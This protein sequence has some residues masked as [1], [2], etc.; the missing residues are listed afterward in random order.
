MDEW[1][2]VYR[3][4]LAPPDQLV[5]LVAGASSDEQR[6][7]GAYLGDRRLQQL[8]QLATQAA[9]LV[10]ETGREPVVFV[11]GFLGSALAVTREGESKTVWL[12]QK[13]IR[14]G[15]LRWLRLA[16]DGR[17][18]FDPGIEVRATSVLNTL[19][20]EL[21]L[22]LTTRWNV[23]AFAYDWRKDMG[24]AAVELEAFLRAE[25][26]HEP[27][28]VVAHSSGATV[29]RALLAQRGEAG[30][31]GPEIVRLIALGEPIEGTFVVPRILA[32]VDPMVVRLGRWTAVGQPGQADVAAGREVAK[33]FA[34]FPALYQM[35]PR[36]AR[37]GAGPGQLGR[38]L[39]ALYRVETYA[40]CPVIVPEAHLEAA[41][42]FARRLDAVSDD[43]IVPI[44]QVQG[45]GQPTPVGPD[46]A[47]NLGDPNHY[48]LTWRGDGVVACVDAR[49]QEAD[50]SGWSFVEVTH[51]GLVSDTAVLGALDGLLETGRTD[52]L[53]QECPAMREWP[54]VGPRRG[55]PDRDE[56][57]DRLVRR[58]VARDVIASRAVPNTRVG[59]RL[60]AAAVQINPDESVLEVQLAGCFHAREFGEQSPTPEAVKESDG[61]VPTI[62]ISLVHGTIEAVHRLGEGGQDT[63]LLQGHSG[64]QFLEA[65]RDC[66]IDAVAVGHYLGVPP[67]GPELTLDRSISRAVHEREIHRIRDRGPDAIELTPE[68]GL[69]LT[70]FAERG[71]LRGELGRPFFLDDPRPGGGCT[72]RLIVIAGMGIAG[73][74]GTPELTVLARELCWSLGR[75]GRRHLATVLIG[76]GQGNIRLSDAVHAWMSGV[77]LALNGVAGRHPYLE[78]ITFVEFEAGRLDEFDRALEAEA[79]RLCADLTIL[80]TPKTAEELEAAR[81]HA[82]T[83]EHTHH[84][85][86]HETPH[87]GRMSTRVSV[88]LEGQT[89]CFGAITGTA[90]IPERRIPLR[91]WLVEAANGEL[92]KETEV[93][94]QLDRG[95]F[96]SR[97]LIPQDLRPQFFTRDPLVLMLD[98]STARIHWEMVAQTEGDFAP[99]ERPSGRG[100][101]RLA[102]RFPEEFFLGTARGLTRQLRTTFAPPPEPPPPPR[103]ILRVLVV[104]DPAND[105][106]LPGALGEGVEVAD[107]FE[108]FNG[109]HR[110]ND[111]RVEIVRLL[112]PG[113]ATITNVLREVTS[114][115]YDVLHFAG[116]CFFDPDE[117]A[118]S[119]WVFSGGEV[120]SAD[121]LNRIDRVPK[122]V[123]S[124]ACESG[125]TP[126]R[127][128]GYSDRLAPSFAEAFFQRGVSNFICTAWPVDDLA[129][130]RFAARLYRGLLGLRAGNSP[131]AQ[132]LG[133]GRFEPMHRA[134][135]EARLAIA[136]G[137]DGTINAEAARTWGAYQ[138]YGDPFFR[139]FHETGLA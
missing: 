36:P 97:L 5:R 124:N 54:S 138:H 10:S 72:N 125:V 100:R 84:L 104:A 12:D 2:F 68:D 49:R 3:F 56:T 38:M 53:H 110:S 116:H 32:G 6:A 126:A 132:V 87:G 17:S 18:A 22:K 21:L 107:L 90:S 30:G 59:Q 74:F 105:A 19:Y 133:P 128:E 48:E 16:T 71:I 109:V 89:Y 81:E 42:A 112:G 24:V 65:V 44:S 118:G 9:S 66:P 52:R 119:G 73:R 78:R 39:D 7:L 15:W 69:V 47:A 26:G 76:S 62:T 120:L 35:L 28:R 80:Y 113:L 103:R 37:L 134:M 57:F 129:A 92:A 33:A 50:A 70:Q 34:S 13:A 64:R 60:Q 130:R 25:F 122:F 136:R 8:R 127:P 82:R 115:S 43:G 94:I 41:K 101:G 131:G 77:A 93:D 108:A 46:F 4:A 29:V 27:V 20:S 99:G 123:F 95:Q 79:S 111:N 63:N 98:A 102:A 117:P 55:G 85:H 88:Q 23:R 58:L 75:L 51:G 61:S 86:R 45:Y 1:E 106:P 114:Q 121:M 31:G 135:L 83:S 91:P 96:L 11:P 40:S 14:L 137:A 67:Q 139:F